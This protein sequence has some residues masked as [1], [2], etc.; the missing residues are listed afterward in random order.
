MIHCMVSSRGIYC[1]QMMI[2]KKLVLYKN[3][4]FSH[5]GLEHDSVFYCLKNLFGFQVKM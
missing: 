5:G 4:I 1:I 3:Y 2:D